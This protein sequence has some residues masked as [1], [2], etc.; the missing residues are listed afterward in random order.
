MSK[1][2][3]HNWAAKYRAKLHKTVYRPLLRVDV[4]A[5]RLRNKEEI[6]ALAIETIGYPGSFLLKGFSRGKNRFHCKNITLCRIK[7]TE[8]TEGLR[9]SVESTGKIA[10]YWYWA[11]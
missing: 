3:Y 10:R 8:G 9:A 7:I 5:E 2:G 11:G 1:E 4:P 6:A